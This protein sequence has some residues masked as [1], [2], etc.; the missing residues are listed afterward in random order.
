M[1]KKWRPASG[2]MGVLAICFFSCSK[3]SGPAATPPLAVP[4]VLKN[5]FLNNVAYAAPVYNIAGQPVIKMQ[6]SQP[7]LE[8]SVPG[9]VTLSGS[10]T[11]QFNTTFLNG[12][13]VLIIQPQSSLQALTRFTFAIATSLKSQSGGS[14]ISDYKN[15]FLHPDRFDR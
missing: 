12:D 6:F 11:I 13:S 5:I 9:S 10:G 1:K 14:F 8:S 7:I 15:T 3:S 4:I 2:L